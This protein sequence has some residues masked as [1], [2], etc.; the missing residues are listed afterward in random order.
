MY[1]DGENSS[2]QDENNNRYNH[3][4]FRPVSILE[5]NGLDLNEDDF[6]DHNQDQRGF[7]KDPYYDPYEDPN[8]QD[9]YASRMSE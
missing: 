4:S 5:K 9:Y 7:N 2:S 3:E 6:N 8:H 1:I